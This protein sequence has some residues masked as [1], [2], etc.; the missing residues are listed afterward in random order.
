L[1]GSTT[2]FIGAHS[3]LPHPGILGCGSKETA[4]QAYQRLRKTFTL[5]K[6]VHTAYLA[7]VKG[8]FL[9]GAAVCAHGGE[10]FPRWETKGFSSFVL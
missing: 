5:T 1:G 9:G 6:K 7:Y 2:D 4:N 10:S 3:T 8:A